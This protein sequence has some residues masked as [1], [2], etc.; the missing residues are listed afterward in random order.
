MSLEHRRHRLTRLRLG[1]TVLL[2][3]ACL[4]TVLAHAVGPVLPPLPD[5]LVQLVAAVGG[6][7]CLVLG[8]AEGR[9]TRDVERETFR[10]SQLLREQEQDERVERHSHSTRRARVERVLEGRTSPR[11]VFQPV[12]DLRTGEVRGFEALSRFPVGRPAEWFAEATAVGLRKELELKAIRRAVSNLGAL[13]GASPYLAM[14][15]SPGTLLCEEL[16]QVLAGTDLT[17]IVLE[18]TEHVPVEDHAAMRAALEPLRS[19]GLRLAV[20]HV[21]AGQSSLRHIAMLEPDIIKV[22]GAFIRGL[23]SGASQRGIVRALVAFGETLDALVV[24]E[25]VESA[26]ALAVAQDLGVG[27]G[28]GWHLGMPQPVELLTARAFAAPMP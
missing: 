11:M 10:L 16:H 23:A 22:D 28:Q 9:L 26:G 14:N 4:H 25:A 19:R 24:A 1:A 8:S 12:S 2:I 3:L 6:M 13:P 7:T 18:L 17:R 21:G 5:L 15:A 27:A 20:D